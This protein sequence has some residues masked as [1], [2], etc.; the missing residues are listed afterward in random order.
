MIFSLNNV[1]SIKYSFTKK[2]Q[3]AEQSHIRSSLQL[4]F[5]SFMVQIF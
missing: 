2:N 1:Q 5:G 3:Q 4:D